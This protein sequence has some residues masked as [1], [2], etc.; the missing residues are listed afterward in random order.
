[1]FQT[2]SSP[3]I[4]VEMRHTS[5]DVTNLNNVIMIHIETLNKFKT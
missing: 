3:N 1:M 5:H 4:T 2:Y